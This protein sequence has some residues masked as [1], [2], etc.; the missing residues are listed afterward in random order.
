[1]NIINQSSIKAKEGAIEAI[2]KLVCSDIT[3][4][5]LCT[6][7]GGNH[8]SFDDFTLFKKMQVAIDGT[9]GHP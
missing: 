7:D 6:G 9:T 5:I 8:K 3:S 4:A 1:L 2:T